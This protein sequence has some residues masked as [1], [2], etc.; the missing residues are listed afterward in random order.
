MI[1]EIKYAENYNDFFEASGKAYWIIQVGGGYGAFGFY[2]TEKKAEEYRRH[3]A[4]WEHAVA[5]KRLASEA[6]AQYLR[7]NPREYI[8]PDETPEQ[9]Q[10]RYEAVKDLTAESGPVEM[11]GIPAAVYD[12]QQAAIA[13]T[14]AIAENAYGGFCGYSIEVSAELRERMR[15]NRRFAFSYHDAL[16]QLRAAKEAE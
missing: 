8:V 2:G 12:A 10:V 6:E 4:N 5:W 13:E 9:E 3:K 11:V 7:L 15:A 16:A 1:E 14:L